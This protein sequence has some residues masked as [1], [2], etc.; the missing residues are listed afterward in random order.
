MNEKKYFH[1]ITIR[2]ERCKGCMSCVRVCPTEALRVREGKVYLD[3]TRCVDCGKCISA[4]SFDAINSYS[5]PLS[6]IDKFPYK[7]AIVAAAYAGQFSEDISYETTIKALYHLG[8]DLVI[9]ESMIS[10]VMTRIKQHYIGAHPDI[11][12]ILSVNCPAVVRLIQVRFPSLLP[13]LFHFEAPMSILSMYYRDKIHEEKSI[14]HEQ[15]GMFL[16]VSCVSQVTAVH[17]P[18]GAYKRFQDGAIAI[19]DIYNIVRDQMN[20]IRNLDIPVQTHQR[21]LSSALSGHEADEVR[22]E[23]IRTISVSGINNVIEILTKVENH[24]LDQYDYIVLRSCTNGCVGGNLTVENPFIARSK[25]NTLIR[26][27]K[28]NDREFDSLFDRYMDGT[29]DILPLEPRSIMELDKDIRQAI[30]KMKKIQEIVTQLPNI[31]CCACG[32]PNCRALA[33]D[34]VQG[35]AEINDCIIRLKRMIDQNE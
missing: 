11:R 20:T 25:I 9:E 2:N 4:C 32:C 5:D 26:D 23:K 15:I 28:D 21:G 27:G 6:I 17:Q 13:N 1:A 14:P 12:P 3:E 18:E 30:L 35:R 29:Y 7:V 31:D 19:K 16:I 33:E 8:F 34:I 24:L 22:N 10:E